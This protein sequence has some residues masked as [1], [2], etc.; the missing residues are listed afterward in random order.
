ME[1]IS[2]EEIDAEHTGWRCLSC[3]AEVEP[4][5]DE[6]FECAYDGELSRE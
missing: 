1:S 2:N 3:D 6:C 5:R 4:H